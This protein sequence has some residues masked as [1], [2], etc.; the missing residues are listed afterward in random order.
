ME[1]I[2]YSVDLERAITES[3]LRAIH[4][5]TTDDNKKTFAEFLEE[6]IYSYGTI[7]ETD[8]PSTNKYLISVLGDIVYMINFMHPWEL[9]IDEIIYSAASMT[10]KDINDIYDEFKRFQ[11]E[12]E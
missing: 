8:V 5:N 3:E 1:K 6:C 7:Y 9:S 4:N 11:E 10:E 12:A 2:Y